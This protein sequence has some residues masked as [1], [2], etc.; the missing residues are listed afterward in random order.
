[1]L[2]R[3]RA[4]AGAWCAA[5]ALLAAACG[6]VP[7][8]PESTGAPVP[9]G[10]PTTAA[11]TPP[12]PTGSSSTAVT[13]SP[14]EPTSSSPTTTSA[15]ATESSEAPTTVPSATA[16]SPATTSV[17]A[18]APPSTSP[19]SGDAASGLAVTDADRAQAA[20]IVARMS[21]ADRAASVLMVTGSEAIG[22]G[23][24]T[25]RH[26]GGVIL[27][28]SGG[29]V[30]GTS[31][32]TPAQVAAVTAK[33]RADAATDPAGVPPLIA[34]DQEYGLVQR[35]KN[36][37]TTFPRAAELGAIGD[38]DT[39]ATI[40]RQVAAAAAEEMR[41]VGVTVD[42]APVFGVLPE[43]GGP[44]AIGQ[45]GRSY[46]SD[47]QRVARLVAAAVSGYQDGGVVASM[48]HFP[49]LARV[50]AD[51]HVTLPTLSVSC[52]D[53]NAHEA[54]PAQAGI[55]A[56]ALMVMTGHVL[57]PA[58]G[59]AKLPASIS[60]VVVQQLLQGDGAAGCAGMGFD[61]VTVTDSMQMAPI[62]DSHAAGSAAVAALAAGEDLILM[63][64]NPAKAIAGI[65][66]AVG[67]GSLEAERLDDAATAVLALRLAS[68]RV[69]AP[70]LDVVASAA[71][72]A[73]AAEAFAAGK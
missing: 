14:I 35:L 50:G 36:G 7:A 1:M 27:F 63:S 34:T 26:V 39:A 28:A 25:T 31:K 64:A 45:Y 21:L 11:S 12:P 51:S 22:T 9:T 71:H 62:T 10:S 73:L 61:G 2:S 53:W 24:L 6:G 20:G 33:L 17:P 66:A 72:R 69:P 16:T 55:D 44:S 3:V 40:T 68:A 52:A 37:F 19:S 67:D 70:S 13:V 18:S 65:V 23:L 30:D 46:G 15:S 8:A 43:N 56:G 54:I 59:D 32:G 5:A 60:P 58:A 29:V 48:K 57:L 42:F 47:P 41:A 4:A 49:G 38:I